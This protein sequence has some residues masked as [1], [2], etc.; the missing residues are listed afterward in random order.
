MSDPLE[1]ALAEHGLRDIRERY[2]QILLRLRRADEEAYEQAVRR[3][4]DELAPAL[5]TGEDVLPLW[6]G[7]GMELAARLAPGRV[8]AVNRSGRAEPV[9]GA[10]PVGSLLLHLPEDRASPA[11]P[12]SEPTRPSPPQ[13]AT[14]ELLCG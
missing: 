2:R 6:L 11:I 8:V 3:Y 5:E 9:E 12:L 13:A 10:P 14:L 1:A 4:R 7:Y